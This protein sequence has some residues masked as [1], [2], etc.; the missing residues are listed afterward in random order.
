MALIYNGL[1]IGAVLYSVEKSG[2]AIDWC[3]GVGFMLLFT[4]IA[5]LGLFYKYVVT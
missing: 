3:N 4:A 2:Q 1:L 5:Y